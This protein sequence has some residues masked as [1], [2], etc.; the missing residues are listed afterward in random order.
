GASFLGL[1]VMG[2]L[3]SKWTTINIPFVVSRIKDESESGKVD[4]QTVQNVLYSIMP[5]AL[6]LGITMLVAWMLRKAV[7][8]H[9]IICG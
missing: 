6:P 5:G 2:A 1:F 3:V 9:L 7:N 4:V 8:P